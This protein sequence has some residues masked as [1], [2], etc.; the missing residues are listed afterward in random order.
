MN[1]I[2]NLLLADDDAD[3]C[4]FFREAL[5]ELPLTAS[6]TTVNDG[7]ELINF[8]QTSE[9]LPDVLFLDLN[10]PRK[11]GI[12]CLSEIKQNDKLANLP[13]VIFSTSFDR[14]VVDFL[15]EGGA[16]YYIRKPSEFSSLKEVI[17]TVLTIL[18]QTDFKQP[19]KENFILQA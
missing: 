11:T 10:M 14:K 2:R 5:D 7:E 9:K 4:I 17:H 8:L 15:Y 12:E 3:D 19:A 16:N 18:R 13:V 6:L 1:T